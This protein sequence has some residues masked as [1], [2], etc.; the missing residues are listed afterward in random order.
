MPQL[1]ELGFRGHLLC[2]QGRLNAME[3]PLEPSDELGLRD[4]KLGVARRRVAGEREGEPVELQ[5]QFW[6]QALLQFLYRLLVDLAKTGASG[7]V[8][9][10]ALHLLEQLLDHR[11]DPHDLRRL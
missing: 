6:R 4:A 11:P 5:D 10:S 3:Q 8:Q 9:R 1:I 2:E 7:F